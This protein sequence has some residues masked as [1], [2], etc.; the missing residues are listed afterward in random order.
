MQPKRKPIGVIVLGAF[1]LVVLGV[2]QLI[3][4]LIPR[5]WQIVDKML[6]ESGVN[7]TLSPSL[8]KAMIVV[9]SVIS[10][11]FIVCGTGLLFRRE[12]ARKATVYFAFAIAALVLL[13]VLLS[14]ASIQQAILQVIYP[15]ILIIYF[16]NRNIE[17]YFR[18]K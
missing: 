15:G 7:I 18:G 9:Q 17:D 4:F 14:P 12:W 5:N 1:N 8:V 11:V 6:K 3:T 10:L 16:T 2:I 13:S